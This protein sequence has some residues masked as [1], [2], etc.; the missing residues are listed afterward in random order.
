MNQEIRDLMREKKVT[1]VQVA[2]DLNVSHVTV[3]VVLNGHQPSKRIQEYVAKKLGK[4]VEDLWPLKPK[5]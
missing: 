1:N 4:A 2:H 3:S 5:D